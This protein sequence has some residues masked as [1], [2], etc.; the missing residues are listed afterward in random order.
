MHNA[1]EPQC[2][3]AFLPHEDTAYGLGKAAR[4]RHARAAMVEIGQILLA[5]AANG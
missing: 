2:D 3:W 5:D 1:D 4:L